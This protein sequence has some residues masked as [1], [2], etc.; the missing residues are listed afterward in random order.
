MNET[1]LEFPTTGLP[2]IVSSH[3]TTQRQLIELLV[4]ENNTL[5][6]TIFQLQ[7]KCRILEEVNYKLN[8]QSNVNKRKSIQCVKCKRW[9]HLGKECQATRHNNGQLL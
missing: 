1:L 4:T 2:L 8:G 5:K 6:N 9:G 7:T 3:I